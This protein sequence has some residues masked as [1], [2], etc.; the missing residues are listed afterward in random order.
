MEFETTGEGHDSWF[1][2]G[3]LALAKAGD[4]V[5]RVQEIS[6]QAMAHHSDKYRQIARRRPEGE[7]MAF[8]VTFYEFTNSGP[9]A[10]WATGTEQ[11]EDSETLKTLLPTRLPETGWASINELVNA[12]TPTQLQ[13]ICRLLKGELLAR[14]ATRNPE[15]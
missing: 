1:V 4:T 12:V 15:H 3:N 13:D 5:L 10:P 11:L 2:T 7:L 14:Q 8:L 9:A 6:W